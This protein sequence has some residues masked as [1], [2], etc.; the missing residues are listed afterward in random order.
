MLT[1]SPTILR[2]FKK[3]LW[4]TSGFKKYAQKRRAF[5]NEK[6]I[7]SLKQ[8]QISQKVLQVAYYTIYVSETL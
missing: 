3:I 6:A 7:T 4:F 2:L 5:L 8:C 1:I